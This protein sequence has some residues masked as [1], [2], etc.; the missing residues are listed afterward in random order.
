MPAIWINQTNTP[1]TSARTKGRVRF[2]HSVRDKLLNSIEQYFSKDE[3]GEMV[4]LACLEDLG[5]RAMYELGEPSGTPWD[6]VKQDVGLY[7]A[8]LLV[9]RYGPDG[10]ETYR[11]DKTKR[12]STRSPGRSWPTLTWV[13][14]YTPHRLTDLGPARQRDGVWPSPDEREPR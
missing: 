10:V 7:I 3:Y 8:L 2:L 11:N 1:S 13:T 6:V 5:Q 4:T 12:N 14:R 9:E